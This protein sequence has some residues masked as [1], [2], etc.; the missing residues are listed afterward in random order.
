MKEWCGEFWR[1]LM[2]D[3][4]RHK[5]S[6]LKPSSNDWIN[7]IWKADNWLSA[8]RLFNVFFANANLK[9][10]TVIYIKPRPHQRHC[11]R[12]RQHCC[13]KHN[14]LP[15]SATM[16]PFLATLSRFLATLSLVWTGLYEYR[17]TEA[18][19]WCPPVVG[20]KNLRSSQCIEFFCRG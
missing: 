16:S 9:S 17:T 13:Q 12:N 3:G 15:V 2:T 20:W 5:I 19:G 18:R 10:Q 6:R 1:K 8:T 11:R 4:G 7:K 14:M